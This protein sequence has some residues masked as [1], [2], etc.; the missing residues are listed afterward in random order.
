MTADDVPP[1]AASPTEPSRAQSSNGLPPSSGAARSPSRTVGVYD[2]PE[3][4][5]RALAL[6]LPSIIGLLVVLALLW[7]LGVFSL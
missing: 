6:L 7:V 3:R 5:S 4:P 2:R 1:R